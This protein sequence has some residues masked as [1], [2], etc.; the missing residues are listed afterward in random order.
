MRARTAVAGA[1][2]SQ[3]LRL[4]SA[5][6]AATGV[7]S[8]ALANL[9]IADAKA[10]EEALVYFHFTWHGFVELA[11]ICGTALAVAG[12][13]ALGGVAIVV[14]VV[15]ACKW[16][17]GRVGAL[18]RHVIIATDAR[19]RLTGETIAAARAVKMNGWVPPVAKRLQ[20]LRR[21]EAGPL[22]AAALARA[23]NAAARDAAV[24]F[25]SLATFGA[26]AAI[27]G[28]A[29]L[30]PARVFMVLALFQA[31]LRVLAIA[32]LGAT[33]A[34]EARS[35]V[36]RLRLFLCA[37]P[38]G[39]AV[40]PLGPLPQSSESGGGDENGDDVAAE[41]AELHG[42]W[43][44]QAAPPKGCISEGGADAEAGEGCGGATLRQLA[45]RAR[46]GRLTAVVGP[47]GA[48]KSSLLLALLGE[49]HARPDD[50][51]SPV[52]PRP[53]RRLR[54]A[55]AYAP[56]EA[57]VQ[58]ASVRD[59][60]L[61]R[62]SAAGAGSGLDDPLFGCYPP[63]DEGRYA[64]AL[65][66]AALATDLATF[67][68]GDATPVGERG[69]TL[70][71]GQRARVS[72][73]R[74]VYAATSRGVAGGG[75]GAPFAVAL[76]DD[77][78]AAVDAATG[79]V[80][81]RRCVCGALRHATR[82]LVTHQRQWL[83]ACDDVAVL[84]GGRLVFLGSPAA[85]LAQGPPGADAA[86]AAAALAAVVA[87]ASA[88][89]RSVTPL[90]DVLRRSLGSRPE[91]AALP[92]AASQE[93]GAPAEA[94][95]DGEPPLPP[96]PVALIAEEV[97]ARITDIAACLRADASALFMLQSAGALRRRRDVGS[98]PRVRL[99][100]GRGARALWHAAR[101]RGTGAGARGHGPLARLVV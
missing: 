43:G 64:E 46:A 52:A 72:L 24:P 60:I 40:K 91:A 99:C 51:A 84:E 67:P 69:V 80:L 6:M 66:A 26:M 37:G 32:P 78:L 63:V 22:R 95:A 15:A 30:G 76:L 23:G 27:S 21:A 47:V 62:A 50:A 33:A 41:P 17:A 89:A 92:L 68:S 42:S 61:L 1:A 83:S 93:T 38:A 29:G 54:G 96:P 19:V 3:L 81:M 53:R 48:G 73:A 18:R 44:W 16:L 2:F 31:L 94:A 10:L 90:G 101:L 49:L 65:D 13:P 20:A 59:N 98:V 12:V 74:A 97:R 9:I 39:E 8:G 57:W 86:T 14:L 11:A 4:R 70:S 34:Q 7:S 88:P 77:P 79:S 100:R 28:G 55:V 58:A 35:G 45:F 5:P 25:A 71:G 75:D 36:E 85:L 82:I 56:Q 87:V